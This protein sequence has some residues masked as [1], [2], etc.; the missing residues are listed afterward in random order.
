MTC[1]AV[2]TQAF[3]RYCQ[4]SLSPMFSHVWVMVIEAIAVTIAMYCIIQFYLQVKGDIAVHKPLLKVLAIKLVI[5]L[6]FWQ[7]IAISFFTSTGLVKPSKTFQTPDIRVGIPNFLLCVEMAFFA[8]FHFWAFSWRPYSITSPEFLSE[9]VPGEDIASE[10][11]KGGP[12]GIKAMAEAFNPWDMIKAIGRAA[13]WL[14]VGRK[15]RQ[16]DRSY[17]VPRVATDSTL[18]VDQTGLGGNK[19]ESLRTEYGGPGSL[20]PSSGG[21]KPLRYPR[22]GNDEGE[23]LIANAQSFP[24]SGPPGARDHSPSYL[25]YTDT[26]TTESDIGVAKSIYEGDDSSWERTEQYTREPERPG[27]GQYGYRPGGQETGVTRAPYPDR[28]GEQV[29]GFDSRAPTL[30]FSGPPIDQDAQG[31]RWRG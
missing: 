5:F 16:L 14:F 10:S 11:Y 23:G 15:T 22:N 1:V 29:P 30:V 24:I 17:A 31:R 20:H 3:G 25:T 18:N 2:A 9:S 6:S 13:K 28:Q 12:L 27:R 19:L 4:E 21:G 7:T 8:L 26:R